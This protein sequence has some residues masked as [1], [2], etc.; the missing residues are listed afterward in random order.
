MIVMESVKKKNTFNDTLQTVL[1]NKYYLISFFI[2][3]CGLLF[4]S[5]SVNSLGDG[6]L[7][8]VET[9][10]ASFIEFRTSAGFLKIFFSCFL[11][12]FSYLLVIILSSLGVI[13][14]P[15]I[16][17][18]VFFRG[19]GSAVISGILYREYSLQGIAF[20]NLILLPAAVVTDFII[21]YIAG[22]C[23]EL[24]CKFMSLLKDF[25]SRGIVIKAD[26]AYVFKKSLLCVLISII[27]SAVEAVFSAGFIKY[28]NF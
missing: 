13:G 21:V 15:I 24:S 1:D 7:S 5:L 16:P 17:L 27:V 22:K 11:T 3:I 10:F 8:A 18:T 12:V 9:Y 19:F 28:F 6:Y 14:I 25:S 20:A 4:G 23:L 2:L 26:C